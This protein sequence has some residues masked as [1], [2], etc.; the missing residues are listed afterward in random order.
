MKKLVTILATLALL[1]TF[2]LSAFAAAPQT[3][4][5]FDA[6]D[7]VAFMSFNDGL[8][9]MFGVP[10]PALASV[11]AQDGNG[12]Q[13]TAETTSAFVQSFLMDDADLLAAL[14]AADKTGKMLAIW[15]KNASET[16][17]I[18]FRATFNT[19]D[20]AASFNM[21]QAKLI[22]KNGTEVT[23]ATDNG[24]G[25]GA[26]SAVVI[27]AGFEG[28]LY[29]PFANCTVAAPTDWNKPL[30]TEFNALTT[31]EIDVRVTFNSDTSAVYVLDS[32][33]VTDAYITDG[34]GGTD[35][36]D[37]KPGDFSVIAYAA[38]ALTGCGA[39]VVLKKKKA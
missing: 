18:A 5:G 2:G 11:A 37:T 9:S 8:T 24:G 14:N 10:A 4:T 16:S 38:A 39:L 28:W 23:I 13:V 26:D 30:L 15:V 36:P 7:L 34:N 25:F 35:K 31:L 27:P 12:V 32:M 6:D 3:I 20:A 1:F 29:M 21:T 33:V 19:A 17:T 22:A